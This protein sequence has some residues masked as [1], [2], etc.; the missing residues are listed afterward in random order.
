MK[1]FTSFQLNSSS[2]HVFLGEN[3]TGSAQADMPTLNQ[4]E[5]ALKELS[6]WLSLLDHMVQNN[7]VTVGD[8]DQINQMIVKQK[9][10]LM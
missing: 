10:S 2:V 4:F 8:T 6:D 3:L 7:R 1:D 5:Q 9:V